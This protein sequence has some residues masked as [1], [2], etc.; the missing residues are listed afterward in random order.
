L[1]RNSDSEIPRLQIITN[2]Q[3]ANRGETSSA[4]MVATMG[5]RHVDE[6]LSGPAK[7]Y[8]AQKRMMQ[9]T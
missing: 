1:V 4:A 3:V 6:Y 2:W 9:R 5:A 7:L 8:R